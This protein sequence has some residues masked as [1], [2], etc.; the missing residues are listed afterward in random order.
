[1][2]LGIK[3]SARIT[4]LLLGVVALGSCGGGGGSDEAPPTSNEPPIQTGRLD[5]L[6]V[7]VH[8]DERL[9][10]RERLSTALPGFECMGA[11]PCRRGCGQKK[12]AGVAGGFLGSSRVSSFDA[13]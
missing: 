10:L 11:G 2:M 3:E 5:E 12:T 13:R 4:L 9:G 6:D 7:A 8:V 1:M